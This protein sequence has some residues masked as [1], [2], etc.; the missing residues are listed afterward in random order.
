MFNEPE[1]LNLEEPIKLSG[2]N[3]LFTPRESYREPILQDEGSNIYF[4]LNS[5]NVL[6][7]PIVLFFPCKQK[8]VPDL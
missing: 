8:R 1:R 7:H 3:T 2:N 5:L 6:N 4:N